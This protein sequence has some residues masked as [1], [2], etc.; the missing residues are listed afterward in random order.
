MNFSLP[1]LISILTFEPTLADT[2][3][4]IA[5]SEF[6]Y[7]KK[8]SIVW[9][10][11][12]F[13]QVTKLLSNYQGSVAT[14][15]TYENQDRSIDIQ[16]A[17]LFVTSSYE[18]HKF[19]ANLPKNVTSPSKVITV[20]T[21]P[22]PDLSNIT[23]IAWKYYITDLLILIQNEN[24]SEM[25]TYYPYRNNVCG[26]TCPIKVDFKENFF[27]SKFKNLLGC[28]TRVGTWAAV[29]KP[30]LEVKCVNGSSPFIKGIFGNLFMLIAQ[31]MNTTVNVLCVS[32]DEI[33]SLNE[34]NIHVLTPLIPE[35]WYTSVYQTTA[36]SHFFEMVWCGPSQREIHAWIKVL[37]PFM[38]KII[39]LLCA[40]FIALVVLLKIISKIEP[41]NK[42]FHIVW[43]ILAILLGQQAEFVTKSRLVNFLFVLWIWF[44]MVVTTAYN[45]LLVKGLQTK[46][47]EPRFD[48]V[49]N[50]ISLVDGYGGAEWYREWYK[51]T[52]IWNRFEEI[53]LV[54]EVENLIRIS[55]GKRYLLLTERLMLLG[56]RL[57]ILKGTEGIQ[58]ITTLVRARWGGGVR[59]NTAQSRLV[60]A[61]FLQKLIRDEELA[62]AKSEAKL[63]RNSSDTDAGHLDIVKLGSCFFFIG[64][65]WLVCC[66]ILLLEIVHYRLQKPN[67]KE[68]FQTKLF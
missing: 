51:G 27:P 5:N 44:S 17:I 52:P 18:F 61:G 53:D 56:Y 54:E 55:Q 43:N 8:T 33:Y 39:V 48:T 32:Y 41:I 30:Y 60:E 15:H 42:S 40:A 45:G 23:K 7:R 2:A 50:A 21:N 4:F 66:L 25:Y 13:D 58:A 19:V 64:I 20:V 11:A 65:M 26:N 46:L 6:E 62:V 1:Y 31:H 16:Q 14:I 37:V 35:D 57:Q 28:Q 24:Q 59:I 22:I 34:G 9:H 68:N 3:S 36:I 47:L 12:D 29:V 63:R 38:N 49:A 10:Q 67:V